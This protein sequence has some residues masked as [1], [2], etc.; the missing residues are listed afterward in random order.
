[1]LDSGL[2]RQPLPISSLSESVLREPELHNT[3]MYSTETNYSQTSQEKIIAGDLVNKRM[4]SSECFSTSEIHFPR[5]FGSER[6]ENETDHVADVIASKQ[7]MSQAV[8]PK[9]EADSTPECEIQGMLFIDEDDHHKGSDERS[10]ERFLED[11]K[12]IQFKE[13]ALEKL[14]D[15][16]KHI[17]EKDLQ[18]TFLQTQSVLDD[19]VKTE[20]KQERPES[21]NPA[22][23]RSGLN[24][25]SLTDVAITSFRS[26]HTDNDLVQESYKSEYKVEKGKEI[27]LNI[28]EQSSEKEQA[29]PL[30]TRPTILKYDPDIEN[31][32]Y[33]A[34][35]GNDEGSTIDRRKEVA[36][37][38]LGEKEEE[39]TSKSAGAPGLNHRGSS[40]KR[41]KEPKSTTEND[42]HQDLSMTGSKDPE[43]LQK[44]SKYSM[45]RSDI[46][47]ASKLFTHSPPINIENDLR[48]SL[49]QE[50]YSQSD[51]PANRSVLEKEPCRSELNRVITDDQSSRVGCDPCW[52]GLESQ[53]AE[54]ESDA[55]EGV[56]MKARTGGEAMW[57]IR[58]NTL[59]LNVT[60]TDEL[61]TC[62]DPGRY[63]D[64]SVLE[65]DRTG[66]AEA[67]TAAY[68]I[69]TTSESTPE[70]MSAGEKAVI[71]KLPQETALSDRPI[72]EKETVFD[73]HEG[74]NDGSH[75]PL[76]RCNTVGVLYDTKLE[77]GSVSGIYNSCALETAQGEMMS[78]CDVHE[79]LAGAEYIGNEPLPGEM[80]WTSAAEGAAVP[81]KGLFSDTSP[82][83]TPSPQQGLYHDKAAIGNIWGSCPYVDPKTENKVPS[84]EISIAASYFDRSSMTSSEEATGGVRIAEGG[85][86]DFMNL[87]VHTVAGLGCDSSSTSERAPHIPEGSLEAESREFPRSS[88]LLS[89][90]KGE[91][92]TGWVCHQPEVK[93]GKT[94]GPTILIRE[95]TEERDEVPSPSEG[96]IT[97][98]KVLDAEGLEKQSV[99]YQEDISGQQNEAHGLSECLT[100]KHIGYKILY[101]LLFVV[102]CVTMY[103]YDLIVC[104][105]LYLFSL[106]WLYCEGGRSRESVKKE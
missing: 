78:A 77:K 26:L 41:N 82:E 30:P 92:S 105:V 34:T 3:Q 29:C 69:K 27:K 55:K 36:A 14:D 47:T 62:Q 94:L 17:H 35:S 31:Q 57:G 51:D 56:Q 21:Q 103:H 39:D 44:A 58:D 63:E 68:I 46:V 48:G 4:L 75:Y 37:G 25:T 49:E 64:S 53:L 19:V 101:F 16:A 72:E 28:L 81:E 100:L 102:F 98:E 106:Y 45:N 9:N 1:M 6:K 5:E 20:P 65:R 8:L 74:R 54:R 79:T 10:P 12:A 18:E 85:N 71:V 90:E 66:E 93:Q 24:V 83:A 61:F 50:A 91:R 67:V 88:A 33:L 42:D 13:S 52:S 43:V 96:L 32:P 15:T 60:P 73:I 40:N 84:S 97:E 7:G 89:A 23:L 104:F 99:V 11:D 80:L 87:S 70:K 59:C 2:V 22:S 76:C 95:P 38:V 86:H